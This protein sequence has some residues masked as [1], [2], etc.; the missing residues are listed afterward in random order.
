MERPLRLNCVKSKEVRAF[1]PSLFRLYI[2]LAK[3]DDETMRTV[4]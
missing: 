3:G 1:G 2:I 4:I